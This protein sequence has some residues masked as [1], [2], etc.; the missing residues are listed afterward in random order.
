VWKKYAGILQVHQN[1]EPVN[2]GHQRRR[3]GASQRY[4]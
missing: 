1:A 2:R 4:R 3:R